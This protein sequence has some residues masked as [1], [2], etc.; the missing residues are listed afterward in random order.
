MGEGKEAGEEGGEVTLE[1][2]AQGHSLRDIAAKL[3]VGYG[4]VRARLLITDKI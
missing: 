3:G 4:T 2:R 1:L